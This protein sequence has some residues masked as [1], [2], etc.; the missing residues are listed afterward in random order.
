MDDIFQDGRQLSQQ[1]SF[2]DME[3]LSD[4]MDLSNVFNIKYHTE[5]DFTSLCLLGYLFLS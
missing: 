2:S 1:L 5:T 3:R 4:C